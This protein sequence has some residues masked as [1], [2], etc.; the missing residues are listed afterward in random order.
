MMNP[1]WRGEDGYG[2]D[3]GHCET[4]LREIGIRYEVLA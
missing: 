2:S 3:S 1:Y 4:N